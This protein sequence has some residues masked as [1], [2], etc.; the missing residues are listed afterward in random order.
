[1]TAFQ[2]SLAEMVDQLAHERDWKIELQFD[3]TPSLIKGSIRLDF[4]DIVLTVDP[5]VD[6]RLAELLG[7]S[8]EEG[9][10]KARTLLRAVCLHEM[11][12]WHACP[13][14]S[15]WTAQILEGISQGVSASSRKFRNPEL[16][17][18]RLGNMF[19][20]IVVNTSLAYWGPEQGTAVEG[21][22]LFYLNQWSSPRMPPDYAAFTA[23]QRRLYLEQSETNPLAGR[24][25]QTIQDGLLALKPKKVFLKVVQV[26]GQCVRMLIV[27]HRL[28]RG[29]RPGEKEVQALTEKD[30]WQHK[31]R[32][33]AREMMKLPIEEVEWPGIDIF[34]EPPDR[35]GDREGEG[36]KRMDPGKRGIRKKGPLSVHNLDLL[37][38]ERAERLKLV[39][40]SIRA[41]IGS[42]FPSV[43]L[44]TRRLDEQEGVPLSLIRWARTR[45]V[46]VSPE[47]EE[48]W[49]YRKALPLLEPFGERPFSPPD[50]AFVV[51]SSGSMEWNPLAGKGEYDLLLRAL[52]SVWA[53]LEKEGIAPY[54]RY[55]AINFSSESI[56][57]G[58]RPWQ[59]LEPVKQVLFTHQ[60]GWTYLDPEAFQEMGARAYRQFV[61]ILI[62]DGDIQ[63]WEKVF[64]Q[65]QL[66]RQQ[67]HLFTFIQI[68]SKTLLYKRLSAA[69]FEVHGIHSAR[70]LPQLVLGEVLE[71]TYRRITS[72]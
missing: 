20:D 24:L 50:L 27:P 9:K 61:A 23:I 68:G 70:D 62:T 52:Y 72:F 59:D 32:E 69:G 38:R 60:N 10:E 49:L 46:P 33:F 4:W 19:A 16:V 64:E 67:G 25:I 6:E 63:N 26:V 42:A 53:W 14:D 13:V 37:Y 29:L 36:G 17:L 51:D 7:I 21:I 45:L 3:P 44:Q 55:A 2:E 35:Q 47:D 22:A 54:I 18:H 40:P 66:L 5:E 39:Y 65:A 12:H 57:S 8:P 71:K 15:Q 30:V 28:A 41:D 48:M 58:W 11:A 31:A 34:A 1:M 56:F 43:W